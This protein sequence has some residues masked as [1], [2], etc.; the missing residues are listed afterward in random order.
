MLALM[1]ALENPRGTPPKCDC[2]NLLTEHAD[3]DELYFA[4]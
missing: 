4:E 2:N 1:L 3:T